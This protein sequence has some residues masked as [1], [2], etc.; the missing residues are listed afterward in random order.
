MLEI[1]K[2]IKNI[3]D[4]LLNIIILILIV[5]F[6]KVNLVYGGNINWVEISK[7]QTGI[8]YLDK[9]SVDIKEQGI[10]EITTKYLKIDTTNSKK[11]EENIYV[12]NINCLNNKYKDISVNGKKNFDAKWQD[13][14]G[15]KLLVDVISYSCKNV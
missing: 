4:Y 7:T 8:Q 15:D 3:F 10:I 2:Y 6:N 11:I 1:N 14:N 13:H 5:L 9:D 12:M